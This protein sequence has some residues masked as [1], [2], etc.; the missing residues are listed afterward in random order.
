[1]SN[2]KIAIRYAKALFSLANDENQLQSVQA[3]LEVLYKALISHSEFGNTMANPLVNSSTKAL[4][5]TES[6][7]KGCPLTG[8]FIQLLQQK[9][10]FAVLKDI[11]L[12]FK[13]KLLIKE[14]KQIATVSSANKLE[15]NQLKQLADQLQKKHKSEFILNNEVKPDLIGGLTVKIKDKIYDY[16]VKSQL[17]ALSEHLLG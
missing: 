14:N 13:E 4:I 17:K 1:M 15:N 8:Q 7:G 10:R 16:S 12:I 2:R 5:I 9:N 6:L 11:C 3:D